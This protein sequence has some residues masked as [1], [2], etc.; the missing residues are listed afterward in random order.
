LAAGYTGGFP[1]LEEGV[2][3]YVKEHLVKEVGWS[4]RQK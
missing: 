1:T 4:V 3:N 2:D